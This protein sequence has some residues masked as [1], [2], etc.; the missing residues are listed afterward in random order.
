M[1]VDRSIEKSGDGSQ[2]KRFGYEKSK[3]LQRR[4]R[5]GYGIRDSEPLVRKYALGALDIVAGRATDTPSDREDQYP[6]PTSW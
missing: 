6:Q 4:K 2:E 3:K 1:G 5:M